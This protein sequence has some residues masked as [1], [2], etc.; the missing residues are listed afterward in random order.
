VLIGAGVGILGGSTR[1]EGDVLTLASHHQTDHFDTPPLQGIRRILLIACL[2]AC[3]FPYV[4]TIHATDS[5]LQP[6]ALLLGVLFLLALIPSLVSNKQTKLVWLM[7]SMLTLIASFALVKLYLDP[8][9][10][11]RSA[12]YYLSPIVF[13]AMGVTYRRQQ[14][15]SNKLLFIVASTWLLVGLAQKFYDPRF[16]YDLLRYPRTSENRGVVGLAAEPSFYA[17]QSLMLL[18]LNWLMR[19]PTKAGIKR[20]LN[21]SNLT[22]LIL[23]LQILFLAQSFFGV[24]LLLIFVAIY[25]VAKYPVFTSS[26]AVF[27]TLSLAY[28]A[29]SPTDLD[30]FKTSNRRVLVLIAKAIEDPSKILTSDQSAGERLTD[31][32]LSFKS[33]LMEPII[34]PG[35]NTT[36][37][38]DFVSENIGNV[39]YLK[40]AAPGSRIMSGIGSGVFELG[41]MGLI[42]GLCFL[43]P[44][45]RRDRMAQI[46]AITLFIVLLAATPLSLPLVGIILGIVA[47]PGRIKQ[48]SMYA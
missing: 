27:A 45:V 7:G 25:L 43:L 30:T 9:F 32:V 22:A 19:P 3:C 4:K 48:N 29:P 39:S 26:L 31:I 14:M 44:V 11:L 34:N 46:T 12:A 8:G 41:S 20:Y 38:R 18:I 15:F 33:L 28:F 1:G 5:D 2:L 23:I 16:A 40:F 17:I 21:L 24:I 42:L 13:F 6:P 35:S 37:W 36:V 10:T 47:S